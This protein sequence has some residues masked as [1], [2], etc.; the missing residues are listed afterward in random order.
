MRYL[1]TLILFLSLNVRGA[2]ISIP[3]LSSPVMDLGSFLTAEEK[4]SLSDLAYE[5]YTHEG[6][7]ITIL[8]VN[9]L[10]GL[11]I[12]D[13]SMKVAEKWQLG[14][15]EKDNGLLV[16]LSKAE[17]K[18]RI[19]VGN[20]IEGDVTD[21]ETARYTRDIFPRLFRQGQ[22]YAGFRIF[23]EDMADKFNIKLTSREARLIQRTPS[24]STIRR[25]ELLI[26]LVVGILIFGSIVFSK[27]P[28]AR[29]FFTALG[30]SSVSFLLGT[31]LMVVLFSFILGL[32]LGLVGLGNFLTAIAL[33]GG[34]GGGYGRGGFGGGGGWSGGGGGFSGGGSSGSW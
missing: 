33:S 19:E 15:K 21:Y 8:T 16:V 28:A 18:V 22:F 24:K 26:M 7:Q 4:K 13:F 9:D 30:F 11:E 27:R 31:T 23:M 3:P 1:L 34:R 12:E 32:V 25:A 29:G 6:P 17:R 14:S 5:I 2:E 10:Q 20:G